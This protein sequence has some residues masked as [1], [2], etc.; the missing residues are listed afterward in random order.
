M[1]KLENYGVIELS[2]KLKRESNGGFWQYVIG[3]AITLTLFG[4][5]DSINNPESFWNGVIG[6]KQV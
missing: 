4:V 3:A 6:K 1:K 5:H 2:T